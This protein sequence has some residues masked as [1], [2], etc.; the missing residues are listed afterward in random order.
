[1]K[2]LLL[3]II[4]ITASQLA[5][6]AQ[7]GAPQFEGKEVF[8]NDD[9]VFH[10]IDE[11]T[12]VGTGH[13]SANE[14]IYLIEGNK[15][16][17]LLD[18]ASKITDL[19]KIV[20]S[21]TDKPVTLMLTHVHPDHVGAA[22]YFPVVYMNPGDTAG[23]RQMMPN[24]KGEFR[25]LKDGEVIDLGGR[26]LQVVFTPGHTPGC[27]TYIDKD[28]GYGFSGDSFGSGNLLL[29]SGPFST[30]IASC[31][32]TL[33][34]MD[35][36]GIKFLYPGHFRGNNPETKQ[37]LTDLITL[38]KDVLSGKVKGTE[39]AGNSRF[40]LNYSVSDYGVRVSYG[41]QALK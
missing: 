34:I 8:K 14:S 36:E 20:A 35:K 30:L 16:A 40:G 19:D 26:Q 13:L 2:N 11:H 23:A 28:A 1:M 41:P 22:D 24:Y 31:E 33:A 32:K 12:W 7:M 37:R 27:V 29:F 38:S 9:V 18:A 17:V 25:Y 15:K 21:I 3:S 6:F 4:L 10:Q 39:A 5:I